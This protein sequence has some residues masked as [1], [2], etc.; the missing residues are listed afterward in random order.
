VSDDGATFVNVK[1]TEGPLERVIGDEQFDDVGHGR[2]CDSGPTG[3]AS[4]R[5]IRVGGSSRR[6][7]GEP[8]AGFDLDAVGAIHWDLVGGDPSD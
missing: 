7:A 3:L 1:H 5:Y 4:I 2:S 8:G 6:S